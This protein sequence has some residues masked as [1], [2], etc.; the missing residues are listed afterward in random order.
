MCFTETWLREDID[1]G[2]VNIDGF[3]LI[4]SDMTKDSGKQRG[5]SVCMYINDRWANNWTVK[6]KLCPP[7]I[8]LLTVGV[9]P[10]YLPREFTQIFFLTVYIPP[11]ADSREAASEIASEIST[12]ESDHPDA[13]KIIT[14]DF[15]SCTLDGVLPNHSVHTLCVLSYQRG[16]NIRYVLC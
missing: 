5:G 6:K 8:E 12:L 14:G 10:F 1:D 4:R 2:C 13:V 16:Q 15:N 3:S 7:N 9:R 11:H